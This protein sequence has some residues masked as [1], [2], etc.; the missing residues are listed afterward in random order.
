MRARMPLVLALASLAVLLPL[1]GTAHAQNNPYIMLDIATQ[2]DR[3]ILGQLEGIY[4]GS[5]PSH[6]D[7]L[8]QEGSAAILALEASL[9]DDLERA[10][11]SFLAAMKSFKLITLLIS[12]HT[13]E[14]DG[15][16]ADGRDL[17]S[18]VQRL[19]NYYQ[20]IRQISEAHST[21]IDL[22]HIDGLFAEADLHIASGDAAQASA[23]IGE[24][25]YFIGI[26]KQEVQGHASHS[27]P[28]RDKSLTLKQLD[29]FREYLG[30]ADPADPRVGQAGLLIQE[31]DALLVSDDIPAAKAGFERL[32]GLIQEIKESG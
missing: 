12:E 8:Y 2:A 3:Q 18:E 6:I 1:G 19:Y 23:V 24:L 26:A 15:A 14:V 30:S 11:E 4:G 10:Q 17:E 21:G 7:E 22:S 5:V 32:A 13:A 27:T 16:G 28:D 29:V 25:E 20:S 31:I 9:P